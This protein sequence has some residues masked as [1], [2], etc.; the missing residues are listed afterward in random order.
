MVLVYSL[1]QQCIYSYALLVVATSIKVGR[2][3]GFG[4]FLL[5]NA[6]ELVLERQP[7]HFQH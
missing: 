2:I 1:L 4:V 5:L 3:W 7:W 6:A